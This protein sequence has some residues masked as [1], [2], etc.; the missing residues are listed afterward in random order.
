MAEGFSPPLQFPQ[1]TVECEK[2]SADVDVTWFCKNC[3][4]SLCNNCKE[5]HSRDKLMRKH[6]VVPR[7]GSVLRSHGSWKVR[8]SCK[9]H[10]NSDLIT[11]C[12]DCKEPCC[13][14]CMEEKHHRHAFTKLDTKYFEAESRLN[15]LVDDLSKSTILTIQNKISRL[16]QN[17][18]TCNENFNLVNTEL[19]TAENK[20]M[21]TVAESFKKLRK[22]LSVKQKELVSK[23]EDRIKRCGHQ[24]NEI[25]SFIASTEQKIR[26][27]GLELIEYFP[28]LPILRSFHSD[29][30]TPV[31]CF[32]L[33]EAILNECETNIGLLCFQD[34]KSDSSHES[35][36]N[37]SVSNKEKNDESVET[38]KEE[39]SVSGITEE[40]IDSFK[41]PITIWSI[42]PV[43][44]DTAWIASIDSDTIYLYDIRGKEIRSV[45]MKGQRGFFKKA[46]KTEIYDMAVQS[47]GDIVV[48]CRDEKVRRVSV[49]GKITS[50]INTAPFIPFG[51]CLTDKE[52]IVV[53]MA[54]EKDKNHVAVYTPDGKSKVREI[55]ARDR[56]NKQ[57]FTVP[58][59]VIINEG[60]ITVLNGEDN[61]QNQGDNVVSVD[62]HSGKV[63]WMYDGSQATLKENFDPSGMCKDKFS[64]ILVTDGVNQCIHYINNRGSLLS[65]IMVKDYGLEYPI[66]ICVDSQS[67]YIWC[68]GDHDEVGDVLILKYLR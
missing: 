8:E 37:V 62:Q 51:V 58:L 32:E 31:P 20:I 6:E 3:P 22:N 44:D 23:R 27:G 52:E 40:K 43:G 39:V 41:T 42:E 60:Q 49:S 36:H 63:I 35:L 4:A 56:N 38:D 5:D 12:N 18:E 21:T 17:I 10:K 54:G 61:V 33:N 55:T 30:T 11:Y 48:S 14:D 34:R 2:C 13:I 68:G 57:L 66:G 47:N 16:K 7:S 15:S 26:T 65:I 64:N 29:I 45:K 9:I 19:N 50:L 24:M 67:G 25:E 53:C 59:C 46:N 1:M 28:T